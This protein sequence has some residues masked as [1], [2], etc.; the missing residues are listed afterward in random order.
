MQLLSLGCSRYKPVP[1]LCSLTRRVDKSL[2]FPLLH[3]LTQ[4]KSD[5]STL[6]SQQLNLQS[7]GSEAEAN[8][9]KVFA[10][11]SDV[12]IRH[13]AR[14]FLSSIHFMLQPFC[15][16]ILSVYTAHAINLH[17]HA[18]L[19]LK[20]ISVSFSSTNQVNGHH[21]MNPTSK[22]KIGSSDLL[23]YEVTS[24]AML[25]YVMYT[26]NNAIVLSNTDLRKIGTQ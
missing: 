9:K 11:Q 25:A 17:L 8:L 1:E 5:I 7:G 6:L 15:S 12:K 4:S 13:N 18:C 20:T 23:D 21:E 10:F 16:S 19:H 24:A 14:Q 3:S 2:S 22:C 26:S